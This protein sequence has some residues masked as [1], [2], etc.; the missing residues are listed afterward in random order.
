MTVPR[1]PWAAGIENWEKIFEK[2]SDHGYHIFWQLCHYA[3]HPHQAFDLTFYDREPVLDATLDSDWAHEFH[4]TILVSDASQLAKLLRSVTLSDGVV[5]RFECIWT[6]NYIPS[7]LNIAGV[8]LAQG[9]DVAGFN[10]ETVCHM[11]SQTYRCRSH[12]EEDFFLA[13]WI[14]S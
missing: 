4:A 3:A 2:H 13:R 1:P 12:A 6:I 14:A 8:D 7:D 11:I 10:G 5:I 9:E